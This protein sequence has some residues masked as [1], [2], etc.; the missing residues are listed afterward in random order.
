MVRNHWLLGGEETNWGLHANSYAA[1]CTDTANPEPV[2]TGREWDAANF[3]ELQLQIID[4]IHTNDIAV[5][6]LQDDDDD[7]T[8][9]EMEN[10]FY[11][12]PNGQIWA[13]N[14]DCCH[15]SE[16]HAAHK[17]WLGDVGD[18]LASAAMH[19]RT[20]RLPA[21]A[22]EIEN[23][24]K[25]LGPGAWP[26]FD[27][28]LLHLQAVDDDAELDEIQTDDYLDY[29]VTPSHPDASHDADLSLA[30]TVPHSTPDQRLEWP[31]R[32]WIPEVL[33][34]SHFHQESPCTVDT[35]DIMH[36]TCTTCPSGRGS[37]TSND[38]V[39][40]RSNESTPSP[41]QARHLD[42][43]VSAVTPRKM[44][45]NGSAKVQC[46][47]HFPSKKHG[48]KLESQRINPHDAPPSTPRKMEADSN[49]APGL[50]VWIPA[51]MRGKGVS[52]LRGDLHRM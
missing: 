50:L 46:R 48:V 27:V 23:V 33:S 2:V 52:T 21:R 32:H 9:E 10:T 20:R 22:D 26:H 28:N 13:T 12:A 44:E 16:E 29:V 45:P 38:T 49:M 7:D 51:H 19:H 15:N 42:F 43:T 41:T 40:M 14:N 25:R 36:A 30:S 24:A 47:H 11:H 37:E 18:D 4:D 17:W 8:C 3:S 1:Q 5:P 31:A 35:A 6:G 39:A 34:S